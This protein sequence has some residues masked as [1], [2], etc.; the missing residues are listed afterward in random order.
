M[1]TTSPWRH[2][3]KSE[4]NQM[5]STKPCDPEH[6]KVALLKGGTSGE[7]EISLDSGAACAQALRSSGFPV[8]EVDTGKDGFVQ[9][10][11]ASKPDVVFIALHGKDGEDGCVQGLCELLRLPY[12]GPGV[13]AS[14]LA[15]DKSRAKVF[16]QSAGL[17]TAPWVELE[18]GN[19]IDLDAIIARV[20]EHC[21]VKPAR[22][23][24]ALGV[25]I[26]CGKDDLKSAIDEAF[27]H[28]SEVVVERFISGTE[29]TVAVLGNDEPEAL[30][31]IEIVPQ[32]SSAFY[33]FDAKYSQGGATHIIPARLP[34]ETLAACENAACTAHRALGCRGVS[35]TDM[36]V[37]DEGTCWVLETNTIPGMTST[38]L[39]PDTARK[40]GISFEQLCQ[41][42]VE[43]A[44][45]RPS[46][47]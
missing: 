28:D 42:L 24:S 32:E 37:D 12:T 27:T 31:V 11:I 40:V 26:V 43:L 46:D 47:Y 22:E 14:A 13:L 36:I 21:V 18:P 3:E 6:T 23:G 45:E 7:R 44:L 4:A 19:T 34:K 10:L 35:R 17:S 1:M 16:F 8:V 39:L 25:H 20:G 5:I 29:V 2:E 38:S 15:M 41:M 33:D 9:D 30:P